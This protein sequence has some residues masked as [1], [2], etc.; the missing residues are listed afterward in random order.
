MADKDD[1]PDLVALTSDVGTW[2]AVLVT[3]VALIGI[4][5]PYLALRASVSDSNRAMNAVKDDPGKYVGHGYKLTRGLRV[6]RRIRVPKLSPSYITNHPDTELLVPI[7][8]STGVWTLKQ[9]PDYHQWNSGWAKLAELIGA[10]CFREPTGASGSERE[11]GIPNGG[12]LE[13]V[14]SR[15]ALVVH[16]QWILLLGLLGRYGKRADTG[17]LQKTGI[18][19]DLGGEVAGIEFFK[20]TLRTT[21][22]RR[23]VDSEDSDSGFEAIRQHRRDSS[24]ARDIAGERDSDT[25]DEESGS[26]SDSFRVT[27]VADMSEY[28]PSEAIREMFINGNFGE[29][30]RSPWGGWTLQ[31]TAAPIHGITGSLLY[32]GR[33]M[34]SFSQ[35]TSISFGPHTAR[36]IFGFDPPQK[37]DSVPLQTLF[38]LAH[39][40]L[41]TN[42]FV[43]GKETVIC[44]EDPP[45]EHLDDDDIFDYESQ[46]TPP[47]FSLRHGESG[48][49]IPLSM[50]NAIQCLGLPQPRIEQFVPVAPPPS[51]EECK[52]LASTLDQKT[53]SEWGPHIIEGWV[54]IRRSEDADGGDYLWFPAKDLER[55]VSAFLGLDWDPWGYLVLRGSCAFWEVLLRETTSIKRKIRTFARLNGMLGGSVAGLDEDRMKGL[56]WKLKN[57]FIPEKTREYWGLG[58]HLREL[59]DMTEVQ[60][61]RVPLAMLIILNRPFRDIVEGLVRALE[62]RMVDVMQREW[63]K[64]GKGSTDMFMMEMKETFGIKR[65]KKWWKR[66]TSKKPLGEGDEAQTSSVSG[67]QESESSEK[68]VPSSSIGEFS[69]SYDTKEL[70]WR[71]GETAIRIK[72]LQADAV[73][74]LSEDFTTLG[75]EKTVKIPPE[76]MVIVGLWAANH[77]ALWLTSQDSKPLLQFLRRLDS[78]VYVL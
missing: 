28:S 65:R 6:W 60:P 1:S 11:L 14:N 77:A 66:Q 37:E 39:G 26:S 21:V 72:A 3:L 74:N 48:N 51:A 8:A 70:A 20:P 55:A 27:N 23:N 45:K 69:Y 63:E 18:R 73:W 61:L 44:L 42:A 7:G 15:T 62:D 71:P 31:K 43:D 30:Q 36:Q 58:E 64:E 54:V 13:V 25:G 59:L 17:V 41:P 35:L 32:L 22:F 56:R 47:F 34:G 16:K 38:W 67:Q 12:S 53:D 78:H 75:T 24:R 33:Q 10:Y 57:R 19:R 49:E 9:V 2:V 52:R 5:G 50:G 40:F 76:Q 68:A 4:V 29:A 46:R